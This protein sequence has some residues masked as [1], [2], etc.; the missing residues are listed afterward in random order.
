M[1]IINNKK[2]AIKEFDK[3]I[4]ISPEEA[5]YFCLRGSCKYYLKRYEDAIKDLDKAIE[6]DIEHHLSWYI[7]GN[8]KFELKKYENA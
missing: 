2:D 8:C 3:S 5:E 7:R 6:I 4:E 1:K